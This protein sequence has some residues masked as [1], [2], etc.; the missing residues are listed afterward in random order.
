M[1]GAPTSGSGG[2][3]GAAPEPSG[4]LPGADTLRGQEPFLFL[5]KKKRFLTPKKKRGPVYAGLIGENGGQRLSYD[6]GDPFRPLRPAVGEQGQAVGPNHPP[7]TGAS[8]KVGF[9]ARLVLCLSAG[10]GFPDAPG[11]LRPIKRELHHPMLP[12]PRGRTTAALCLES[13]TSRRLPDRS[14]FFSLFYYGTAVT[15]GRGP[16]HRAERSKPPFEF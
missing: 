14:T 9:P 8:L 1:W 15:A 13:G 11:P 16:H 3:T 7:P 6:C 10:R 4:S 5:R 2:D 12:Q